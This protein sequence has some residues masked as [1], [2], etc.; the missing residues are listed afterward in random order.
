[1]SFNLHL[2][3]TSPT[4]SRGGSLD[5]VVSSPVVCATVVDSDLSDHHAVCWHS[6][7]CPVTSSMSNAVPEQV[8]PRR[9]LDIECF[10]TALAD[11]RLCQPA[12]W[13][14]A[15]DGVYADHINQN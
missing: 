13:P 6:T 7:K 11:S 10:R 12:I 8:R 14:T 4:H 1:M 5:A 3:D 9:R 15:V 2:A